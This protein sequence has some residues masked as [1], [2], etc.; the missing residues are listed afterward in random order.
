[1]PVAV[2]AVDLC[3]FGELRQLAVGA[4]HG[5]HGASLY[6]LHS[7]VLYPNGSRLPPRQA[8]KERSPWSAAWCPHSQVD[9]FIFSP[10]VL[11]VCYVTK[12]ENDGGDCPAAED[13]EGCDYGDDNGFHSRFLVECK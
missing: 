1:M 11:H 4:S 2:F 9:V 12:R 3:A 5:G 10:H 6:P 13:A 7:Q 8:A